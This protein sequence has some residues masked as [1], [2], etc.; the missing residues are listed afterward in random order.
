MYTTTSIDMFTP[1]QA[2]AALGVT[3]DVLLDM[4]NSGHLAAYN[5]GG[6][7]R[8]KVTHVH[9]AGNSSLPLG[10]G[11]ERMWSRST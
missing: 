3:H 8:L 7:I 4:I 9:A 10:S 2:C 6:N 5:L 1:D 11:S